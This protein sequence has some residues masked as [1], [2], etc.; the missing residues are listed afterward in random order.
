MG[1]ESL[2]LWNG[3]K[4]HPLSFPM[5]VEFESW[6][7]LLV[8]PYLR[9]ESCVLV[10]VSFLARQ[11]KM[12]D[13]ISV[14][15]NGSS[16]TKKTKNPHKR[17][18]RV[19]KSDDEIRDILNRKTN[20]FDELTA[21]QEKMKKKLELRADKV[22]L[23]EA[24]KFMTPEE[25]F[26]LFDDDE[27]GVLGFNE[28]RTLLP[29]IGIEIGDAKA[30]RY[31]KLC[32]SDGS[33]EIDID[34]FK[35]ALF[36]CD[37]SSGNP[38][39][40]VPNKL[41]T[42]LDAFETFDENGVGHLDED[43]FYYAMEYLNLK[44]KDSVHER[45]FLGL[46]WN[47]TECIDYI[48]FREVFLRVCDVRKEL[49]DR[50]VEVPSFTFRSTLVKILRELLDEEEDRERRALAEARRYKQWMFSVKDKKRYLQRAQWRAYQELRSSL[51]AAGQVYVFGSGSHQQFS[52]PGLDSVKTASGF[53]FEH[54]DKI[55]SIW[56][57]RVQPEQLVNRL[58]L[59]RRA[60]QQEERRYNVQA[61][62][63]EGVG[64][65]APK[66]RKID[67][68][69][70]ALVSP[71]RGLNVATNTAYLWG[72]RIHHVAISENVIFAV[73]DRGEIYT[74]G[75][76]SHWWHEIQPDSVYQ[77]Q[78]RGEITPRS[79]LLMNVQNKE[80]P[81]DVNADSVAGGGGG[82]T[83]AGQSDD[84]NKAEYIKIVTKYFNVWEPPPNAS[85]RLQYLEKELLSKVSY[86]QIK[87]ALE[88]RGKPMHDVTKMELVEE[89]Y[90]DIILEKRLLGER[91][92]KAIRELENQVGV[93]RKRRKMKLAEK[94]QEN[95]EK[96]WEPLRE[97]QA[98]KRAEELAK[99]VI[100]QNNQAMQKESDYINYRNRLLEK[101]ELMEPTY[102]SR[103]NSLEIDFN[104]LTSRGPS[105][106]L[107]TPRGYQSTYQLSAGNTHV[108]LIHKTGQL[109]SWG[110]G[111]S[112][113]LGHDLSQHGNPQADITK[114]TLIQALKNS[115][116]VRVS[117]GHSHTGAII[118]GGQLFMWG[119]TAFG[120]CGLGGVDILGTQD[121]YCSIPTRISIR[122]SGVPG[123]PSGGGLG[124]ELRI[125]KVSCGAS[126]SA[127][128]TENGQLYVFGCSDGGRLGLG[129]I[130]IYGN[131]IY[132]PTLVESLLH[133]RIASVSCGNT[134]TVALTE[135]SH[136]LVGPPGFQIRKMIG[137][138]VYLAGSGNVFGTPYPSFTFFKD[139][140]D[141]PVKR[142]SCGYQ[143]TA[144][145]TAEG[146]LYTWGHNRSICCGI[147]PH[148]KFIEHPQPIT[149][150][151][152]NVKNLA[153]GCVTV[154]QSSTYH[155]REATAVTDGNCDGYG[156]K[157]CSSTQQD[158]QPWLEID[159]GQIAL[160]DEIRLWNR[161]DVP[162]DS[163]MSSDYFTSRLFP[164]WVMI[165]IDP[166]D[167]T[168]GGIGLQ[169][170]KSE[171]VAKMK[172]TENTRVSCWKCPGNTQGR[173][174]RIQLEGFNFLSIAQVEV[175]GNW[176]MS[177]GVGRVS[178]AIAGRDVTV[179]VIRPKN[180]SNDIDN[181]YQ[182]AVYADAGNADLLRQFETY[183]LEYDKYGRGDMITKCLICRGQTL[184]EICLLKKMYLNEIETMP[185]GIGGRR[186][187]LDSI[188]DYLVN[189]HKPKLVLPTVHRVHRPSKWEAWKEKWLPSFSLNPLSW[190]MG[191]AGGG[192]GGAA[193]RGRKASIA[194]S[195][196]KNT[197][198]LS[199]DASPPAAPAAVAPPPPPSV[200][201][202][203]LPAPVSGGAAA[204]GVPEDDDQSI[205]S[206]SATGTAMKYAVGHGE[207]GDDELC[208]VG[209]MTSDGHV[210]KEPY[211]RSIGDKVRETRELMK[212]KKKRSKKKK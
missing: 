9:C 169:N 3:L 137:G 164:C 182:R 161:T 56:K 125:R 180:D 200:A 49:E 184:C 76:Q 22:K 150:L 144:L 165:G 181:I 26:N 178:Y 21:K 35:V 197:L 48:E 19:A 106:G 90:H 142:A 154:E 203:T 7:C 2:Q 14:L 205:G 134:T 47:Q 128:I 108:C 44:L 152:E 40:Y 124:H 42:P 107:I 86:D 204:G 126:H 193:G 87:F 168:P 105:H 148:V 41:V 1:E 123:V 30:L 188:D 103:G 186:R 54:Y 206:Q 5:F 153:L 6:N 210:V 212:E 115:P 159:L 32:D 46:D 163:S 23:K 207:G 101:R 171:C 94:V 130:G 195:F 192:G 110:V 27:S 172:F 156:L 135:I 33:G 10:S 77:S 13:D 131:N 199:S 173:Y 37:P 8:S 31:F 64:A 50:G 160:I 136:A 132:S 85:T 71:F 28:F 89:L 194:P 196:E 187:R 57:D 80:L 69:E 62:G 16:N 167:R 24:M 147:A 104:G 15:T 133:E 138:K 120:K 122:A 113:R 191:S 70:E 78:W 111:A 151:F 157:K 92:H 129:E 68:Y 73:S 201:H 45:F 118:A 183:A 141:I 67:P 39:G 38:V 58:R 96:M 112:G 59:I 60:E 202:P 143:H 61:M 98:E 166:F 155:N 99:K 75:G 66:E 149:C 4:N 198:L 119:S 116:V 190:F 63:G 83:G 53:K 114:P 12:A 176:G 72:R 162:H 25:I 117:C 170:S 97:V 20:Q 109:Y 34:E 189:S 29:F 18:Q 52:H 81:P 82:G 179:A 211:P 91:A 36:A 43:E 174:V 74:W 146:E 139:M 100:N 55:I 95:I 208:S 65:I 84:E 88:V 79:Q 145:V 140:E 102:T 121:C 93:L 177:T 209:E 17:N 51:D 175:L 127:V 11:R 185:P 158:A